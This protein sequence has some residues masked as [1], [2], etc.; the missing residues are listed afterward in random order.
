MNLP[1]CLAPSAG[2]HP[3]THP[4]GLPMPGCWAAT[5]SQIPAPYV[6]SPAQRLEQ[7]Q[8]STLWATTPGQ[9]DPLC[10]RCLHLP[11]QRPLAG[12]PGLPS[13]LSCA[14]HGGASSG[15]F[16]LGV[17]S[18]DS[19]DLIAALAGMAPRISGERDSRRPDTAIIE[20]TC[21]RAPPVGSIPILQFSL[22]PITCT[23]AAVQVLFILRIETWRL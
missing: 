7:K 17:T 10:G 9:A 4:K 22:I 1:S 23:T 19:L 21:L 13:V 12:Q 16:L 6:M 20:A 15:I 18:A 3:L 5:T 11:P 2:L 8:R 14:A